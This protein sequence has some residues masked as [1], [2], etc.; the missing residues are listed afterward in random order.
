M[1][2][3]S[4]RSEPPVSLGLVCRHPHL[5]SIARI[6]SPT[7][8]R[9][10]VRDRPPLR[11]PP[12]TR[13]TRDSASTH[14]LVLFSSSSF[15]SFVTCSS[16]CARRR[17]GPRPW[18]GRRPGWQRR[19]SGGT[20]PRQQWRRTSCTLTFCCLEGPF[21]RTR[22]WCVDGEGEPARAMVCGWFLLGRQ[23]RACR[24]V[25]SVLLG[26]LWGGR[27]VGGW[28]GER[29][30]RRVQRKLVNRPCSS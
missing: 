23:P 22:L 30:W 19:R 26:D 10:P 17:S 11:S 28:V 12:P 16:C 15:S 14:T 20:W 2:P 21:R 29:L 1:A 7:P 27:G 13:R 3:V 6:A 24:G 8:H 4:M 25:C 5:P 9:P 18:R